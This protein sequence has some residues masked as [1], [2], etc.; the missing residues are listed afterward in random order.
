MTTTPDIALPFQVAA[1][2]GDARRG[3]LRLLDQTRLPQEEVYIECRDAMAV[4]DAIRRL[5]VRGAPAIGI[6]AAYGMV[7]AAQFIPDGDFVTGLEA[8]GEYLKS[9]R[10]TA[11]NLEWAVARVLARGQRTLSSDTNLIRDAL[12]EEAAAIA[13]E[14]AA[15]C[16]AIGR[17]ALPLIRHNPAC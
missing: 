3:Y 14:D 16:L 2:S 10:P 12:L 4:W 17:H 9:S 1:W 6:A 15:L 8:A 5:S 11:V 7:L 13:T